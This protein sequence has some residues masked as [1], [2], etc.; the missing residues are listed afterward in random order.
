MINKG[1]KAVCVLCSGTVVCRTSSV[2]RHFETNHKS[3]CEKSEPEQKEFI[4]SAIKDRNKQSMSTF[5]YVSKNCHTSAASYSA[6]NAIARHDDRGRRHRR[7]LFPEG[8][9]KKINHDVRLDLIKKTPTKNG[10]GGRTPKHETLYRS[11]APAGRGEERRK[12]SGT[13][14]GSESRRMRI[15][16]QCLCFD[17]WIV[18]RFNRFKDISREFSDVIRNRLRLLIVVYHVISDVPRCVRHGAEYLV[19]DY[20]NLFH[21]G[22]GS[23]S[24]Y[25]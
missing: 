5:K 2:K 3:F 21:V 20:L 23:G 17:N 9:E 24:P 15:R 11:R 8:W 14:E 18:M 13:A 25:G 19:L 16:K 4:A 22:G 1:D 7:R 10:E 6:A 12:E